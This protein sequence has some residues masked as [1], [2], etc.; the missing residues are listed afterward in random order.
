MSYTL[1]DVLLISSKF[2]YL[3]AGLCSL[4]VAV[5]PFLSRWR[6]PISSVTLG[7]WIGAVF[8]LIAVMLPSNNHSNFVALFG[9]AIVTV[10]LAYGIAKFVAF[11]LGFIHGRVQIGAHQ[12]NAFDRVSQ[13]LTKPVLVI[14]LISSMTSLVM[15]ALI[16]LRLRKIEP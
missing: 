2:A 16:T 10:L 4:Y 12:P 6:G 14:L 3:I 5:V 7:F 9:S 1:R 13:I 11:R 15:S 8:L